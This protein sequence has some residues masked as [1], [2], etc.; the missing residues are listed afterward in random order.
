MLPSFSVSLYEKTGSLKWAV[1]VCFHHA[2]RFL[3]GETRMCAI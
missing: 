1:S 3:L 2:V